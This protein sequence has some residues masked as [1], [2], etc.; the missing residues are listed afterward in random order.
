MP[1][2]LALCPFFFFFFSFFFFFL[3]NSTDSSPTKRPLKCRFY[4]CPRF[5][6]KMDHFHAIVDKPD[7]DTDRD[8]RENVPWIL[9]VSVRN[10]EWFYP[11]A[12][13]FSV[14]LVQHMPWLLYYFFL[15]LWYFILILNLDATS[16]SLTVLVKSN[17][18]LNGSQSS[19]PRSVLTP[20]LFTSLRAKAGAILQKS[21]SQL[22]TCRH[23]KAGACTLWS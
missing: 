11:P 18:L 9:S 1:G 7:T 12:P 13:P 4:F 21:V 17:A 14:I 2:V 22:N 6:F 8:V 5:V 23:G 16:A 10:V 19:Q 20:H 15:C 3:F